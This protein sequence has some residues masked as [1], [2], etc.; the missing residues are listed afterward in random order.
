M[1]DYAGT[2]SKANSL[3]STA[4]SLRSQASNL[5]QLLGIVGSKYSGKDADA[6]SIAVRQAKAELVSVAGDLDS[7][8]SRIRSAA[9]TVR[10]EELAEQALLAEQAEAVSK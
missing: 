6:Y 9:Q 2:I 4:D 1:F 8:A 7:I 10:D 3:S 5:D